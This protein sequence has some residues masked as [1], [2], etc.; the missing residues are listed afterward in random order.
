L[1]KNG[2]DITI[3]LDVMETILSDRQIQE[4]IILAKDTDYVPVIQRLQAKG[5]K[6]AIL[7]DE[8]QERVFGVYN[9][10]AD[11]VIP[12]RLLRDAA[13]YP[14]PGGAWTRIR[15]AGTTLWM[16]IKRFSRTEDQQHA[17]VLPVVVE[18]PSGAEPSAPT[19]AQGPYRATQGAMRAAV[20]AVIKAT[21]VTVSQTNI[22]QIE[23]LKLN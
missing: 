14:G 21:Q 7:V 10:R 4:F 13:S 22:R 11:L 5:K 3:A 19:D 12:V 6:S 1:L 16:R 23:T 9:S 2:A 20:R 18:P 15:K 8:N 17:G